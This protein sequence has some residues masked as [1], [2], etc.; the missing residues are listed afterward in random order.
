MQVR[1]K[2]GEQ[3]QAVVPALTRARVQA[4][5]KNEEGGWG[6]AKQ[7]PQ[8]RVREREREWLQA[9]ARLAAHRGQL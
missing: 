7:L 1:E 5:E 9:R 3:V 2:G 4:L 8:T 6:S